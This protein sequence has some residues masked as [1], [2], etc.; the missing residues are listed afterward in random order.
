MITAIVILISL[1]ALHF[2]Y[3]SILAPSL[4]LSLRFT[5]FALRDEVRQL[6]IDCASSLSD[7]GTR[8]ISHARRLQYSPGTG[9]PQAELQDHLG[10]DRDKQWRVVP[11]DLRPHHHHY[12]RIR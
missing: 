3:E 8:A 10:R 5:L 12:H 11:V 9:N 6:K 7:N 1:A 4:R 2:V